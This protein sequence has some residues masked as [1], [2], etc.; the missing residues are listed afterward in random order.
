MEWHVRWRRVLRPVA[1]DLLTKRDLRRVRTSSVLVRVLGLGMH[2]VSGAACMQ[3]TR[4][5]I[6][7]ASY[8][9]VSSRTQ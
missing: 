9:G 5:E 3:D 4:Q 2:V 1:A 8:V 7:G 6:I